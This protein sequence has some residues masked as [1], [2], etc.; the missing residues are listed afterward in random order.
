M[1]SI[2][3][4]PTNP[5]DPLTKYLMNIDSDPLTTTIPDKKTCEEAIKENFASETNTFELRETGE[6]LLSSSQRKVLI[7]LMDYAHAGFSEAKKDIKIVFGNNTFSER[8]ERKDVFCAL[9]GADAGKQYD[10]LL[11]THKGDFSPK[12]ALRRTEAN[13]GCIA[14]H[15]DGD[16]ATYT[17]QL[18]LNADDEYVGGRICFITKDGLLAPKRKEG[19]LTGHKREILHGVTRLHR[20]VRYALFVVDEHNGLGEEDIISIDVAF[21]TKYK[22]RL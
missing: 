15:T 13:D 2:F 1:I 8:K 16:Y 5:D 6:T 17:V 10:D 19:T 14:F 18:S 4:A 22:N 20:G 11:A 7:D 21:V 3:Q 9:F 12:I